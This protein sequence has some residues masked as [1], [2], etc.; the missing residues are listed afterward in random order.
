M[1]VFVGHIKDGQAECF[2]TE[3]N[4][5]GYSGIFA[6]DRSAPCANC[7]QQ[8]EDGVM[9]QDAIPFTM[10]MTKYLTSFTDAD[11]PETDM[12]TLQS[13]EP[14]YVVPFLK[15][16]MHW[17]ITTTA[18]D[19]VDDLEMIRDSRLEVSVWDRVF[20][21]PTPEHRMGLY[22]PVEVHREI[23]ETQPGGLGYTYA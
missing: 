14:E 10:A 18:S 11:G 15:Q 3:K 16:N 22:Y 7:L 12:R 1:H 20:D 21:L 5:V 2:F 19:L 13:F 23:T 8:R 9:Y 17:V 4:E 6:F